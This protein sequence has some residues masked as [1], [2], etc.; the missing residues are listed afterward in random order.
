MCFII[1]VHNQMMTYTDWAAYGQSV[2]FISYH[3]VWKGWKSVEV[4]RLFFFVK[5]VRILQFSPSAID[6][7]SRKSEKVRPGTNNLQPRV[8]KRR[9]RFIHLYK[10]F[11][12]A[13]TDWKCYYILLNS[14]NL[15][16]SI[17]ETAVQT[18]PSLCLIL[19]FVS[20]FLSLSFLPFYMRYN[21]TTLK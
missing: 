3:D 6:R 7:K 9:A 16:A 4:L 8:S 12:S 14:I 13:Q 15:S 21:S 19:I 1:L 18:V 2:S 10:L 20:L 17:F 11:V 5:H